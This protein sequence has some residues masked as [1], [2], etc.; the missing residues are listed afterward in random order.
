MLTL[1]LPAEAVSSEES[2]ALE[3]VSESPLYNG[4]VQVLASIPM[5]SVCCSPNDA[6]RPLHPPALPA[7]VLFNLL[8]MKVQGHHLLVFQERAVEGPSLR[9]LQKCFPANIFQGKYLQ[10]L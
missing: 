7:F 10:N 2:V 5:Q 1:H 6:P 9:V 4:A 8:I 3:P